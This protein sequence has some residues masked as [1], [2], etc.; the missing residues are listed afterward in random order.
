MGTTFDPLSANRRQLWKFSY[1]QAS[2]RLAAQWRDL[3]G[4]GEGLLDR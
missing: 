4:Q 3:P 2:S 1:L